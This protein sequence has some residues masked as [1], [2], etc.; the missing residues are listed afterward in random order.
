VWKVDVFDG[1]EHWAQL[2]HYDAGRTVVIAWVGRWPP[3]A[4]A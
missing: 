3:G 2:W 1:R 4:G